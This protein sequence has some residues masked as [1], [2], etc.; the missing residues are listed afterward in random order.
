[1]AYADSK[2]DS[3]RTIVRH[4]CGTCGSSLYI[5]VPHMPDIVSITFGTIAKLSSKAVSGALQAAEEAENQ[6][7]LCPELELYCDRKVPWVDIT[8]PTKKVATQ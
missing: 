1:M 3:K 5:A 8:S 6:K 7:H 4:F 2:T